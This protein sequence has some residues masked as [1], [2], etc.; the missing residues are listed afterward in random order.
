[1]IKNNR[2]VARNAAEIF[3]RIQVG[4]ID[5][6]HAKNALKAL[7]VI[8]RSYMIDLIKDKQGISELP[9]EGD[10]KESKGMVRKIS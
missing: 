5:K 1:M 3:E 7:D 6:N 2:D 4:D 8:Q 10:N 9:S